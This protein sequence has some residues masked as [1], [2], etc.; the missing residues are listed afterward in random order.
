MHLEAVLWHALGRSRCLLAYFCCSSDIMPGKRPRA[1]SESDAIDLVFKK[2]FALTDASKPAASITRNTLKELKRQLLSAEAEEE[3]SIH[4]AAEDFTLEE[5][6]MDF[7]LVYA[8]TLR[9]P[10]KHQWDIEAL[11]DITTFQPSACLAQL[12][13][14]LASLRQSR[15][16]RGRSNAS[17]HG[18]ATDGLTYVFVTITH[19]GILKESRLFSLVH[20]LLSTVLGC[21]QYILETTMAMCPNL[22]P[23]RRAFKTSEELEAEGDDPIYVDDSPHLDSDDEECY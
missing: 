14:Y 16:N 11:P 15:L 20:G 23:E 17:V 7:G 1:N 9:D 5:A 8:P 12:V 3:K 21:L 6:V 4:K 19:E 22:M 18:I 2:L 13:V 10:L